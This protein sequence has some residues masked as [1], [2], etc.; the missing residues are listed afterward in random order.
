MKAIAIDDYGAPATLHDVPAPTPGEGQ[1]LVRVVFSSVNGFDVA[2]A[3]GYL[4]GAMEHRFPVVLG[5]DV[6]GSVEAT[7]SGVRSLEVGD[8]VFGV[9]MTAVLGEGAFGE[10]ATVAERDAARVP[11]GLGMATAGVLGLAGA[12]AHGM[13]GA[14]SPGEGDHVLISGATGGV[15]G[16]AVQPA[17]ARGARVIATTQSDDAD[18]VRGLG[19]ADTVDPTGD[20]AAQVRALCPN[21]VDAVVHL[22]GDGP[23]LAQLLRPDGRIVSALG[24]SQD[25]LTR[26]DVTC[27]PVMAVPTTT[28]LEWLAAEVV[29]G[30]L[31]VP[32]ERTYPLAEVPQALADFA[33]GKRGKLSIQ[34]A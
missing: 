24:L 30:R 5:K 7:G 32:I 16:L 4:K 26:D 28:T 15:G 13:I 1:V 27:T 6:A 10:L 19:A 17:A 25:A 23:A 14:V 2:V 3:N 33:S 8:S 31:T 12:T 9:V 20:L 22:A 29:A 34:I 18:R 21:G 11:E